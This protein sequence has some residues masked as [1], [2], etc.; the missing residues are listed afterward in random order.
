MSEFF[1]SLLFKIL[2]VQ[3]TAFVYDKYIKSTANKQALSTPL[4]YE[5]LI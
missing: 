2:L 3:S 5:T 4:L 1:N